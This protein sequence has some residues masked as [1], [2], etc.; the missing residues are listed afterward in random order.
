MDK[1]KKVL[2]LIPL[3]GITI[4]PY[5]V[6]HFDVGREKSILALEEAM[7]SDQK[8]FLAAQKEAKTEEPDENDIFSIGT[9]CNIKQILKLPGDTVRV[10][11]EGESRG[12][13]EEYIEK[14][15]FFKVEIE[16]LEDKECV[17]SKK[18]EALVRSVRKSFN[19][20]TK[21]SGS[22]PV[23][24]IVTMEDLNSPGRLADVVS[25]Y[26]MLK[27]E[28]KQELIEAYDV[29]ERLEKLLEI[30]INEIDILKIRKKNR[31]KSKN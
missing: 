28:S 26:L 4:F 23:E 24:T 19:E 11:V 9:I 22:I 12:R 13:L 31:I 14:E 6:L 1:N 5:M 7:L 21:L 27:Q 29:E 25:S 15:P 18:C 16:I 10:L 2:P 8:I 3:R 20:Y 30:L 17:E